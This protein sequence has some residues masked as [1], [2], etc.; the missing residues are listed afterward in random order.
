MLWLNNFFMT[1]NLV[2]MDE[3]RTCIFI[4]KL[5][6]EKNQKYSVS[7]NSLQQKKWFCY[8]WLNST[9]CN[10]SAFICRYFTPWLLIDFRK[11]YMNVV[12]ILEVTQLWGSICVN[13]ASLSIIYKRKI[14]KNWATYSTYAIPW[15]FICLQVEKKYQFSN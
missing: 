1:W 13:S 7:K 5:W 12:R 3:S 11:T 8:S 14:S 9:L 15:C 10:Y 4:R 6:K 2:K